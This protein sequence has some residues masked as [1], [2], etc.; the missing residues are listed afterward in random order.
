MPELRD[1][2]VHIGVPGLNGGG[3]TTTQLNTAVADRAPANATYITQTADATLTAEQ[4][5]SS[6]ATGL[7]KVTT[8]TGVLSTATGS[9][10]PTHSH[11]SVTTGLSVVIDGGGATITTGIKFDVEIPF[12]ATITAVRLFADQTGSISVALWK[13]TYANFPPVVGDE[14]GTYG[15]TDAT[16][17]NWTG[18]SLAVAAGDIIRFNVNSVTTIQRCTVALTMT[19]TV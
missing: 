13:D 19:R 3:V 17:N 4:A 18:Q 7:L 9:D 10:V 8:G 5:L 11:T 6:L 14:I 12:A 1:A 16:K 15:I 2:T